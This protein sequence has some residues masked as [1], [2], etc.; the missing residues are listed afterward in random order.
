MNEAIIARIIARIDTIGRYA[1]YFTSDKVIVA[2]VSLGTAL[3]W[4]ILS[5][6]FLILATFHVFLL[7]ILG[8]VIFALVGLAFL[9]V[10]RLQERNRPKK[11]KQ[12]GEL[13]PEL[14]LSADRRN[15]AITYAEI[16]RVELVKKPSSVTISTGKTSTGK[17]RREF[18]PRDARKEEM[19][20]YFFT[21][22]SVLGD[23]VILLD[24]KPTAPGQVGGFTQQTRY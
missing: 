23:K 3:V 10:W 7:N 20:S 5:G 6:A 24:K 14:I 11:V 17:T 9:G 1:L 8:V 21:L 18:L 4:W 22:R 15:I 12:L 16:V 13:P 2:K 19:E